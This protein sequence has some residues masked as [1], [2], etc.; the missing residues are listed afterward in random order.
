MKNTQTID[1]TKRKNYRFSQF[2]NLLNILHY[3]LKIIDPFVD[4][5]L[6]KSL[7][8]KKSRLTF[9]SKRNI[10]TKKNKWASNCK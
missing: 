6:I 5:W 3:T 4:D 10:F 2:F 8:N 1:E 7:L 9:K